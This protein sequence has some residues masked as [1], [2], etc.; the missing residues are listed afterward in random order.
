M[1]ILSIILEI[2]ELCPFLILGILYV[3]LKKF[4]KKSINSFGR[5]ADITTVILFF[6]IPATIKFFWGYDIGYMVLI[7][8]TIIAIVF[9]VF[10]Y[11]SKKE[12]ELVPLFQ[13]IWRFLFLTLLFTY[14]A[15]LLVGVI[16]KITLLIAYFN[17]Q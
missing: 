12:M 5:A 3:T 17:G 7:I 15:I 2:I 10:E 16:Q 11:S 8:A 4:A 14:L 6:S 1:A 9:T 13:K